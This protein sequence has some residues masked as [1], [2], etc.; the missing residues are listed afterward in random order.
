MYVTGAGSGV[1]GSTPHL[2]MSPA[3][4]TQSQLLTVR[5]SHPNPSKIN[6]VFLNSVFIIK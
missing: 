2:V 4:V 6:K 3:A 5:T 1:P